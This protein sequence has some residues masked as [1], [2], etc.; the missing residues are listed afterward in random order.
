M[1][2]NKL[3]FWQLLLA[4]SPLA[5][6]SATEDTPP[7]LVAPINTELTGWKIDKGN[8]QVLD[9]TQ[10]G[11]G[12]GRVLRMEGEG[13]IISPIQ[14]HVLGQETSYSLSYSFRRLSPG[15]GWAGC[16]QVLGLVERVVVQPLPYQ[17]RYPSSSEEWTRVTDNFKLPA[18]IDSATLQIMTKPDTLIEVAD[19]VCI[20]T[21]A[22]SYR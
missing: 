4:F 3:I 9:E 22:N 11:P 18:N 19:L 12:G 8:V 7:S 10:K 5:L 6:L 17:K 20:T 16:V 1:I 15:D 14:G 13:S 2:L 21:P